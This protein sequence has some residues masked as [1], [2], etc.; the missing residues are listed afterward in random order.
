MKLSWTDSVKNEVLQTVKEERN[1]LQTT[2][3]RQANWIG[4]IF[5]RNCCLE[6]IIKGKI[7]GGIEV[8]GR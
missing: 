7:E 8:T 3:L 4:H 1:I 2:N 6:Y 5:H